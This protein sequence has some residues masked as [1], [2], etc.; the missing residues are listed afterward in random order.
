M[1]FKIILKTKNEDDLI[2]IWIRY[3]SKMV[4]KENIVIFD[5]NST[6]QKVLDIYK[7]HKIDPYNI[8]IP[9]NIHFYG[10]FKEFYENIF[11]SCDWFS[12]LDTDEFLCVYKDG[13]FSADGV[14]DLLEASDK[15]VLGSFW[16]RQMYLNQ[17]NEYFKISPNSHD[18][19][20]NKMYGKAVFK[21]SYPR[22]RNTIYGH[23]ANCKNEHGNCDAYLE[24]GLVLLHLERTNWD[25]R[26]KN[27]IDMCLHSSSLPCQAVH[28]KLC[29][30]IHEELKKIQDT[31]EASDTFLKMVIPEGSMNSIHK[32]REIQLYYTNKQSY[33]DSHYGQKKE[34][35]RTNIINHYVFGEDY[36]QEISPKEV[37]WNL[38]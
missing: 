22:L 33:I 30:E 31:N 32:L 13:V 34:Y 11:S 14:I 24:S 10:N 23:N 19:N 9:N 16:L 1:K 8:D 36:I 18:T 25:L 6:S 7:Y 2:D 15:K 26:I 37:K 27:C 17:T 29:K 12:I 28:E 20:H 4:G 21:T 5:N 3:Y 38:I 35:I